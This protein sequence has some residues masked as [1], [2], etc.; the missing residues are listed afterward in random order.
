MQ[1][2]PAEE[3]K[4]SILPAAVGILPTSTNPK[5]SFVVPSLT[6]EGSVAALTAVGMM[7]PLSAT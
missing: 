4:E 1:S 7:G 6:K 5:P 2:T 3:P